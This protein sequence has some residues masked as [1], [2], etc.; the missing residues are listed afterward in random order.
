MGV[1][2]R[3]QEK[4]RDELV[5]ARLAGHLMTHTKRN[6]N[7]EVKT[8]PENCFHKMFNTVLPCKRIQEKS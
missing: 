1:A 7:V 4:R 8:E 5:Q 6:E 3:F 2:L